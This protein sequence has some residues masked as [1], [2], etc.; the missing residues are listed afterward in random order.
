MSGGGFWWWYGVMMRTMWE[1]EERI[2]N[3]HASTYTASSTSRTHVFRTTVPEQTV[4]TFA[5]TSSRSKRATMDPSTPASSTATITPSA[6]PTPSSRK[7]S[8]NVGK[9]LLL[10]LRARSTRDKYL[11]PH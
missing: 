9:S 8:T 1:E 11:F 3:E 2:L 6:S 5:H 10:W 4:R 7:A